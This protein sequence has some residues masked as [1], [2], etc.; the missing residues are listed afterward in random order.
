MAQAADILA[1][2]TRRM[3]L[4]DARPVLQQLTQVLRRVLE[5][6]QSSDARADL[7]VSF[8][9][10]DC[11]APSRVLLR[12]AWRFC[13]R[14]STITTLA[15]LLLP[16]NEALLVARGTLRYGVD[17][18]AADDFEQAIRYGSTTV[19]P[20]YFL[21]HHHLVNNR[22]DQCRRMCERALELPASD[23]VRANLNEWLAISEAELRFPPE[24]IR[25]AF[26]EAIRLA[27]DV[28]R[29]RRN[30]EEFETAVTQQS[31]QP[32][33]WDKPSNSVVQ[34]FWRVGGPPLAA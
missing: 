1:T 9:T 32:L 34:S 17:P 3:T 10:H 30:L 33:H 6:L 8:N 19:W 21:A 12:A 24:L 4:V 13:A 18:L 27:P 22:F 25:S 16:R 5:Q 2:S 26:E 11:H 29:I 14:H 28:D 31:V 23:E 7:G 20:Y 15:C